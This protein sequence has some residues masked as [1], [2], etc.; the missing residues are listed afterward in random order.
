M[1]NIAGFDRQQIQRMLFAGEAIGD[2]WRQPLTDTTDAVN[3]I[4]IVIKQIV[5]IKT[6]GHDA[7]MCKPRAATSVATR[8][9][10][11]PRR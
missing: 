10:R 9:S 3:V 5:D 6:L 1:T 8:I 11:S 7:G 2:R 4:F